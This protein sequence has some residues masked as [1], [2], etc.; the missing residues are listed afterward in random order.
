ML[1]V[2]LP[3]LRLG[4]IGLLSAGPSAVLCAWRISHGNLGQLGRAAIDGDLIASAAWNRVRFEDLPQLWWFATRAVWVSI[5][6]ATCLCDSRRQV[7]L[8]L[9]RGAGCATLMVSARL[10]TSLFVLEVLK[11]L[12]IDLVWRDAM[13]TLALHGQLLKHSLAPAPVSLPV[14]QP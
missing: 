4:L 2:L 1:L 6:V 10:L 5:V 3:E 11:S 12:H 7:H 13:A 14:H 8:A 9:A